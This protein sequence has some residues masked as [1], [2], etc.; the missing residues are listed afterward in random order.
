VIHHA[1]QYPGAERYIIEPSHVQNDQ[2]L[3]AYPKTSSEP[4]YR[5]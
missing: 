4:P 3:R 1:C 2:L 5:R